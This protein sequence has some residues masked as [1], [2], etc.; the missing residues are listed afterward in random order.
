M[1]FAFVALGLVSGVLCQEIGWE[2]YLGNDLFCVQ[3]D[4]KSWINHWLRFYVKYLILMTHWRCTVQNFMT[5]FAVTSLCPCGKRRNNIP[6]LHWQPT[7]PAGRCSAAISLGWQC[8]CSMATDMTCECT[9]QQHEIYNC[10]PSMGCGW[11][12]WLEW[13][14]CMQVSCH[15]QDY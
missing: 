3:W 7:D 9:Q 12:G 11:Y 5:L 1:L 14:I 6:H 8:F 10:L 15:F 2:E 4:V 13:Y